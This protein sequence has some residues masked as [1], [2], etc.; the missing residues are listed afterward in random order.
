M[1][2]FSIVKDKSFYRLLQQFVDTSVR[3]GRFDVKKGLCSTKALTHKIDAKATSALSKIKTDINRSFGKFF[4][5][6]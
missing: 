4:E 3:Y 1:R 2:P 5:L 6:I